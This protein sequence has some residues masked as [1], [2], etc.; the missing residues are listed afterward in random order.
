[1]KLKK[2]RRILVKFDNSD[3]TIILWCNSKYHIYSV[4]KL[5]FE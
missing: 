1:M 2:Y 5:M 3:R 4:M